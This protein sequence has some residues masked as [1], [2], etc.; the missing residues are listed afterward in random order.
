VSTSAQLVEKVSGA[1]AARFSRRGFFAR[2]A[3]VGSAIAANPLTYALTP[4]EAYAAVCGCNGSNCNCGSLCCDGYTEFCCTLSGANQCP[5]GSLLG[6]WWKVD[7]SGFCNGPRYY[8]DCNA[9][10]N[11]CGCGGNGVCSGS[12]S[13]TGCGCALGDCNNRKA[14]CTQFR[15]GQCNQ[16]ISCI[17][18]IICRVVTCIAP[19]EIDG[20][21]A[22]TPLYDANTAFHDRPC[23][24][25][26]VGD[27]NSA[28]ETVAGGRSAIRVQGW[29]VDFDTNAPISVHV[30]VDGAWAAQAVADRS[31][32]DVAAAIPGMGPNHGFDVTVAAGPGT[33]TVC[34]YA[35][36]AGPVGNSN[37]SIGC[38]SV[39]VGSPF[40]NLEGYSTGPGQVTVSGWAIDPDTTGPVAVHVYVDGTWAGQGVADRSRPDVGQAYPDSGPNHGFSITIPISAGRHEVCAYGINVA[41]GV[42]NPLLGCLGVVSGLPIGS[43]DSVVPTAGGAVVS[44]WAFDTDQPTSPID[45]DIRVDG[46]TVATATASL[47]R[48]DVA[49]VYPWAGGNHGYSRTV[50]ASPGTHTVTVV[51]RNVGPGSDQELARRT[52]EVRS[53]APFGNLE[54]AIAGPGKVR[55]RGWIID[56]DSTGPVQ[57]RV[58]VD[59]A[60]AGTGAADVPRPDVAG[61]YPGYGAAHGFEITVPVASGLR[62]VRVEAVDIGGSGTSLLDVRQL[63]VGGAP[64]GNLEDVVLAYG[65]VAVAGWALDPDT[66]QPITLQLHVDGRLAGEGVADQPRPDVAAAYPLYGQ[67]HGFSFSAPIPPGRH[68]VCVYLVDVGSGG[69]NPLLSCRTVG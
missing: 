12:C 62:L 20:T 69:Q 33:H 32:P 46:T 30:Y 66:D 6:G 16:Q 61:V 25:K 41:N 21:C 34:V 60:V 44:G 67:A 13:G 28:V 15:Y 43:V 40:G 52:V 51:A 68:Q 63:L 64:F 42:T 2:S 5:P 18:P 45:V 29:A 4:T 37:P 54:Q 48:P 24:H 31:R 9:P 10:C 65:R 53:G 35:I 47:A 49:Q 17:G 26:A 3:V 58:L 22:T 11:G 7:G 23:L 50:A 55:V 39:R 57:V 19:W 1:L 36:N 27:V 59:G 8:M 56:P 14:G 38:R